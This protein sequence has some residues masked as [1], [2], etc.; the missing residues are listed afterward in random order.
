MTPVIRSGRQASTCPG[1]L[2]AEGCYFC[3]SLV[4]G[5]EQDRIQTRHLHRCKST[6]PCKKRSTHFS[7][8]AGKVWTWVICPAPQR[9]STEETGM[10]SRQHLTTRTI[11]RPELLLLKSPV[12]FTAY[13]SSSAKR[14]HK[15]YGQDTCLLHRQVIPSCHAVHWM[16]QGW[17][18]K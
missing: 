18:G 7:R 4:G 13:F 8:P 9:I 10:E 15:S 12:S 17:G 5:G 1:Q 2:Q 11:L 16:G 6:G 14:R 3:T